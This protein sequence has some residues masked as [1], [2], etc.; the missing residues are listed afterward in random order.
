[1]Q[2]VQDFVTQHQHNIVVL[3]AVV[4]VCVILGVVIYLV[5]HDKKKEGMDVP[6]F[7][8]LSVDQNKKKEMRPQVAPARA[9]VPPPPRTTF[10]VPAPA[11]RPGPVD[12]DKRSTPNTST[13]AQQLEREANTPAM[14]QAAQQFYNSV[15]DSCPTDGPVC[16]NALYTF[17]GDVKLLY[18]L[19]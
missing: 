6:S 8:L 18:K 14:R 15:C 2:A 3:A 17:D 13:L 1:M 5:M 19:N 9:A 10:A 7:G 4:G 16:N 12:I 11:Q